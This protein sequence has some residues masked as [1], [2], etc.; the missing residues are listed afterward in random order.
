MCQVQQKEP[1]LKEQ[2]VKYLGQGTGREPD[3]IAIHKEDNIAFI[4]DAKAYSNGY[5]LSAGDERAIKEYITHYCPKL[6]KEGIK[7]IGFIIVSNSFKP[8]FDNFINEMTWKTDIKRLALISSD[9]LLHLLAYKLKS[10]LYLSDIIESIVNLSVSV[11]L[12][13]SISAQ[14]I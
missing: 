14:D 12:G 7:K 10:S 13:N 8:G 11:S 2:F 6:Q 9:A 4:I 3:L 1:N 5:M